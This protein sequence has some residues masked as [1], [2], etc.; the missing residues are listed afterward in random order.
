MLALLGAASALWIGLPAYRQYMAIQRIEK[1]GGSVQT[2]KVAPELVR[3]SMFP[4]FEQNHRDRSRFD[5]SAT[6]EKPA[7]LKLHANRDRRRRLPPHRRITE[8]GDNLS[9]K[10]VAHAR[11]TRGSAAGLSKSDHSVLRRW[12]CRPASR[13]RWP[14]EVGQSFLADMSANMRI[15]IRPTP[16]SADECL[17]SCE[18][19]VGAC[20]RPESLTYKV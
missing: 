6:D 12:L 18:N 13:R 11:W 5:S 8:L 19:P 4:R 15:E 3:Q 16:N 20:V 17:A 2:R 14:P 9:G 7:R 10:D 1:L